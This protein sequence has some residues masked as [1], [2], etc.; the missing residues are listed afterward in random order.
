MKI[1][2]F[3]VNWELLTLLIAAA[4]AYF[5]AA[6]RLRLSALEREPYLTIFFNG[7]AL[8]LFGWK[9]A[10]ALAEPS[11]IW[12]A[13]LKMIMMPGGAFGAAVGGG[14]AVLYVLLRSLRGGIPLPLLA[15]LASHGAAVFLLVRA[16]VGGPRYGLPTALPWGIALS[17]PA[18]V[19]HPLHLYEAILAAAIVLV[20]WTRHRIAGDGR[21]AMFACFAGGIGFFALSLLE[22]KPAISPALLFTPAQWTAL[23]ALA[24]GLFLPR[25]HILWATLQE[26][27]TT[28]MDQNLSKAQREHQRENDWAARRKASQRT[29][30]APADKKTDGPNRPAE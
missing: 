20:L 9:L 26:R 19:Y 6:L 29:A 13:P 12:K 11:L 23:S 16:V 27:G 28:A 8:A 25:L 3:F 4:S 5:A 15:D 30:D 17:D 22:A 2:P 18:Y 21:A 24:F 10:P 7:F 1:G 14:L